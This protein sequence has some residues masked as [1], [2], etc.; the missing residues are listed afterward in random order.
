MLAGLSV[1]AA[2]LVIGVAIAWV[3]P[4]LPQLLLPSV[5][6]RAAPQTKKTAREPDPGAGPKIL[7]DKNPRLRVVRGCESTIAQRPLARFFQSSFWRRIAMT[8]WI[9]FFESKGFGASF[10][11]LVSAVTLQMAG[12]NAGSTFALTL[13]IVVGYWLVIDKPR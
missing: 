9:D 1:L 2:G 6:A 7:W 10:G 12:A 3:L 11:G 8:S 5:A 13:L 4:R